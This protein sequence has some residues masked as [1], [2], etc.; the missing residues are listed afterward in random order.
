VLVTWEAPPAGVDEMLRAAD[1]LMYAA[2][3]HGKN[4]IRHTISTRT[5][6]AA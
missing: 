2:K 4:A 1:E 5:A 3:R 6:D